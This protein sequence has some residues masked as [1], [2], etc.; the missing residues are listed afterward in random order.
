[1]DLK[2]I[3]EFS[4]N[5]LVSHVE[6]SNTG[7]EYE[8]AIY[9]ALL[10]HDSQQYFRT[11][12]LDNRTDK[13]TIN[14]IIN[15]I[16]TSLLETLN[17]KEVF[18]AT[19]ND[20]I[21]PADIVIKD[22]NDELLGLSIKFNNDCNLNFSSRH[23]LSD[24]IIS[25]LRSRIPDACQAYIQDMQ[26]KYGEVANWYRKKSHVTANFID[27]CRQATIDA[28]NEKESIEKSEILDKMLQAHSPIDYW[29]VKV[30]KN[31]KLEV[32]KN[33]ITEINDTSLVRLERHK[34]S[35]VRFY[36]ESTPL[37]KI[38]VKFNNGILEKG[39][40]YASATNHD[41]DLGDGI[42]AKNGDPFGSWNFYLE[43]E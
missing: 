20:S 28:W 29:I 15:N 4:D 42:Y 34:T 35:Y 12:I 25:E 7:I 23:F 40:R 8:Y 39:D 1:M 33:P 17:I 32:N 9:Y 11:H 21:G 37:G 41:H 26:Q 14:N 13:D 10:D 5:E 31:L 27:R 36:F 2:K 43:L 19:Q 6:N 16:D 18:I 38:Q 30:K 22:D 24:N 3:Q